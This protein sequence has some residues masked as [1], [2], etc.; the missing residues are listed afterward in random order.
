MTTLFPLKQLPGSAEALLRASISTLKKPGKKLP[1]KG[2]TFSGLKIDPQQYRAYC[3][4]FGL[5]GDK[6][7]SPYWFIRLFSVKSLLLAHPEAPFPL[8]GMVHLSNE[9]RQYEPIFTDDAL[10][11][12]CKFGNLLG[13]DKGTAIE[14]VC[15]LS[16]G[17]RLVWEQKMVNLYMGK[18]GLSTIL[19][20][21]PAIELT[22]PDATEN[23]QLAENLGFKYARVSGDYNPIHLHPMGAKL[24]GFPRHII[25]G[26][27]SLNRCVAP[28]EDIITG[29]HELYVSFKKPL[30]L[31]GN[32]VARSQKNEKEILFDVI[33]AKEGYPHLKGFLKF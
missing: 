21:S 20:E 29:T 25:H 27:Y 11:M 15:T 8:P 3:N 4:L 33:N 24:F 12:T 7:P 1:E 23:W 5:K 18:K 16:K 28:F 2:Y 30:Y 9:I 31:P 22:A 26:W 19:Y 6:V 32:V 13:H 10:E 14:I 17:T